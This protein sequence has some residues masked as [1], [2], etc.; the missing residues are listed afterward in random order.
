MFSRLGNII[1]KNYIVDTETKK[2][3]DGKKDTLRTQYSAEDSH[4]NTQHET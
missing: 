1:Y 3:Y 2:N 4:V